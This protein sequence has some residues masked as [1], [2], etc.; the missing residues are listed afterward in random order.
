MDVKNIMTTKEVESYKERAKKHLARIDTLLEGL[1]K[2]RETI[3]GVEES[4]T[5]E[6]LEEAYTVLQEAFINA[7]DV[8]QS[9]IAYEV[10]R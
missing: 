5:K 4:N 9:G 1:D 10:R 7:I 2:V 8:E 6:S 3:N